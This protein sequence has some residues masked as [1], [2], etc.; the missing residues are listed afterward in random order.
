MPIPA[1]AVLGASVGG[2]LLGGLFGSRA[3]KKKAE[4]ERKAKIGQAELQNQM[5]EDTRLAEQSAGQSLL[6]QLS[7]KGFTNIDPATAAQLAQRRSYDFSKGVPEAGAGAGSE[8]L[9]G[10][11]GDIG[12]LA[13]EHGASQQDAPQAIPTQ[14]VPGVPDLRSRVGEFDTGID[15]KLYP[16]G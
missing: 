14:A 10:L 5:R 11:F 12:D 7:G 8:L 3:K 9:S 6:G 1:A 15:Y 4:A 16:R 2:R 13:S